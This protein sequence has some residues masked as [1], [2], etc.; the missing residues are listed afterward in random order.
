MWNN[1]YITPNGLK[2]TNEQ[3]ELG[4]Q[5]WSRNSINRIIRKKLYPQDDRC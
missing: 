1:L 2:I 3:I 4:K 5:T